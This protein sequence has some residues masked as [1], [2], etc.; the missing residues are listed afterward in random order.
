MSARFLRSAG[1]VVALASVALL[2]VAMSAQAP[3]KAKAAA[4]DNPSRWDIFAGYSYLAPRGTVNTQYA[5]GTPVSAS[6]DAVNVGGIASVAYYFN[7][8]L[9]VQG[10]WD[11]HE[12]GRA[13]HH[14]EPTSVRTATTMDSWASAAVWSYAIRM[15]TSPRLRTH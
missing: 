6:Y 5:N 2:S 14:R 13:Y 8:Y 9:G 1:R 10:E 7:R 4:G 11:F 3:A 12:W 15:E